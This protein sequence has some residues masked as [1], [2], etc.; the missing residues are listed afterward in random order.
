M[1]AR[2]WVLATA[3][4]V[5]LACGGGLRAG[6]AYYLL[7]FGS[8]Q[9]P[10]KPEF[11]HSFA[12]FVRAVWSDGCP[13]CLEAHTISWLPRTLQ[14]R[15]FARAPECG[16]NLDLETTLRWANANGER[17]SL[18]GPYQIPREVYLRALK[19]IS[20]LESGSIVYRAIDWGYSPEQANCIHAISG[21]LR[22]EPPLVS[23]VSWGET[24]TFR[25]LGL[26][27]PWI[28]EPQLVHPWVGRALGLDAY[29]LIYRQIDENPRSGLFRAPLSR[30]LGREPPAQA[31]YGS[32]W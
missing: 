12:T 20:V 13:P 23:P 11:S 31:T 9:V 25:L 26:F 7:L 6:E 18:W 3:V 32:P 22:E 10:D 14:V 15:P 17:V 5:L 27:R 29:P 4:V 28:I 8:Q 30:L 19:R 21:V 2:P 16:I 1:T 24:A